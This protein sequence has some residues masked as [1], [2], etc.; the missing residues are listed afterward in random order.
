LKRLQLPGL[1]LLSAWIVWPQAAPDG[2]PSENTVIRVNVNL[3]QV[4]LIVTDAK[5]NHVS[6]LRPGDFQLLED[7][8]P[9][10]ITNFSWA[11]VTPPPSGSRLAALKEKPSLLECPSPS[12]GCR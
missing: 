6:D 9:Q 12:F 10:Q 2:N 1:F 11:E 4:D 5:G 7:G 8:K 3:R